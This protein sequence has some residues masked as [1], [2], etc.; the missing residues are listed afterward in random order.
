V[1]LENLEEREAANVP[2]ASLWVRN[3]SGI[4]RL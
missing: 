1:Q 2:A 4:Q 3:A